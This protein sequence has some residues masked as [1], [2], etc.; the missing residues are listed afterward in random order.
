LVGLLWGVW[1]GMADYAVRGETL[2]VYWPVTFAL[3]VLPLTAWRML[4][5][6]VYHNTRSGLL[7]QVMHFSYTGS[8][9]LFVS[10]LL[11]PTEN[12]L[13]Y[14]LLAAALCLG[15]AALAVSQQQ[16]AHSLQPQI[17]VS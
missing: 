5:A 13:V 17:D 16:K 14:G 7:A 10:T 6:W 2:G 9:G 11:A 1:H 4:M 15:V 3:F 12:M 8:L